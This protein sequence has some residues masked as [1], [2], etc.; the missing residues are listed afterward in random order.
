[1]AVM[2]PDGKEEQVTDYS[3]FFDLEHMKAA[4]PIISAEEFRKREYS[5]L[6]L[7]LVKA[8]L[9]TSKGR[10]LY[11]DFV[12]NSTDHPC[13]AWSPLSHLVYFPSITTVEEYYAAKGGVP[14]TL[15]HNRRPVEFTPSTYS[16]RYIAFPSC[17]KGDWNEDNMRFLGQMAKY[18]AF[19]DDM[20][21]RAFK[22]TLRD[23]V[24]F[25]KIV[26]EVA[27]HVVA[28]LGLFKYAALHVRRNELQYK[29]VFMSAQET[30]NNIRPLLIQGEPIY[31]A[32][33][34]TQ[35]RFFEVFEK[36]HKIYRWDDFFTPKGNNA[37]VGVKIPRKL[38]GCIEQVICSGGRMFA[39]TLESTYTTYIFR[40]RGYIKPPNDEVYFHTLKYSGEKQSDRKVTWSKKPERGQVYQTEHRDMWEDLNF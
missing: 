14:K 30:Y 34:E 37:L 26:F 1:M 35:N 15:V 28:K 25:P 11:L 4:V 21:G 27:A 13:L 20:L 6:P 9:K 31:I 39:G 5:R 24:H 2:K 29:E 38:I 23:H 19:A 12:K 33:D 32:T 7:D 16:A 17:K 8:D 40:L 3:E 10:H 22:R 18:G 36:N